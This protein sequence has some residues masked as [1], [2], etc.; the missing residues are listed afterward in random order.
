MQCVR[1]DKNRIVD[2]FIWKVIFRV[3]T[4]NRPLS[5]KDKYCIVELILLDP[6]LAS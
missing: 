3:L 4:N 2:V 5:P 1:P 6:I